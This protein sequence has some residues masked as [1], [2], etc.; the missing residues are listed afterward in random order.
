M[1]RAVIADDS[2]IVTEIL[3]MRLGR[4]PDIRVVGCAR[5]GAGAVDLVR[6]L[7]PDILLMDVRMPGMDGIEATQAI[8]AECAVPILIISGGVVEDSGLAFRA[9]QAGAIDVVAKPSGSLVDDYARLDLVRHVKLV[10][11]VLPIRRGKPRSVETGHRRAFAP[12][13]VVVVGAS[14]GGPPAL[15]SLLGG[16]PA[17]VPP[18]LAVQ[19]IARGF[20]EGFTTWLASTTRLKVCVAEAGIRAEAGTVYFAPEDRHLGLSRD[21]RLI[22]SDEPPHDGHRP[23]VTR[24][25]ESAAAAAG[26][27][28]VGVLLTGMGRDGAQGL[29]SLRDAGGRTFC[30]DESTCVIYGMPRAAVELAAAELVLPI[31]ELAEAIVH[32]LSPG[33]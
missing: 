1:I 15:A 6:R 12:G 10:S 31:D 19:H 32:A 33:G 18:V 17:D 7:R 27:R 20:L 30:Q 25:F 21:G 13:H 24:L 16:L 29:R 4:D 28:A 3:R 23:S 14:T 5:D 9:I 26:P 2:E 8:M 11:R 22:L